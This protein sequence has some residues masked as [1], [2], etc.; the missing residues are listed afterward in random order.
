MSDAWREWFGALFGIVLGC[1]VATAIVEIAWMKRR[2]A[3]TRTRWREMAM[4]LSAV[5]PN[6]AVSLALAGAWTA[7][8]LT[9]HRLAPHPLPIDAVTVV[10]ALVAVDFTYYWEHRCAHRVKTL[11]SLYH[12]VH[13]S[14]PDYTV[15]TAYRVSAVNQLFSP[16]FYLP[17]V[18]LG[19]HPLLIVCWQLIAFHYQ[20]WLHTEAIDRLGWLDRWFNTPAAHRVHHSSARE[21]TDRNLGAIT[22]VW[23]RLFGTYAPP[24]DAIDYGIANAAPPRGWLALY[25]DPLRRR[26]GS[27]DAA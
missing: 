22:L 26:T 25:V 19:F 27:R 16:S 13:H 23:D 7:L 12:A 14:S 9:A 4:S 11:W 5:P 10:A 8:F 3:L 15:A 6:L 20:A 17:A 24:C 1:G 2:G 21:H 18:L